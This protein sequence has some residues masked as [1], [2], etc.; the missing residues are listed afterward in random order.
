MGILTQISLS[1]PNRLGIWETTVRFFICLREF[2]CITKR[3]SVSHQFFFSISCVLH[4]FVFFFRCSNVSSLTVC[5]SFKYTTHLSSFFFFQLAEKNHFFS[6]DIMNFHFLRLW[7]GLSSRQR[8]RLVISKHKPFNLD[9]Q[10]VS[11]TLKSLNY[12]NELQNWKKNYHEKA[13]HPVSQS[14][15]RYKHKSKKLIQAFYQLLSTRTT[16][17]FFFRF[18]AKFPK[19][20]KISILRK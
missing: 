20:K 8:H 18:A 11:Q 12:E 5:Q 1:I 2:Q 3:D 10:N 14:A 15:S 17:L 7:L 6:L 4:F 16:Q 13:N 9:A 19:I